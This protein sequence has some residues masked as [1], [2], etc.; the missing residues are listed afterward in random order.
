MTELLQTLVDFLSAHPELAGVVAFLIAMGEALLIVG[1]FVPSTVPLVAVGTLV[2]LGKLSFWP[3]LAWIGAG[4]V[5]GD[6]VSYWIGYI[7]RDRLKRS[8]PLARYPALV[9][10]GEDFFRKYGGMSIC[11][12]R[13]VPGV[14][15][16]IPGIAGMAGMTPLRFT[17][18]NVLSGIAW[19]LAHLIPGI[20]TGA[21]LGL[22]G[23][24]SGRLAVVIGGLLLIV[25]LAVAAGRWLVQIFLPL[26]AGRHAAVVA[27][28]RRRPGR[29]AQW[30]A[31]TFDPSHP[32]STG[33]MA[34]ALLLLIA[35]PAF[36][37]VA[38]ETETDAPLALADQSLLN[39]FAGL[40]TAWVDQAMVFVTMLGD[41]VVMVAC[42][43]VVTVY[44]LWRR[45]WG[46]AVGLLIAVAGT[47]LFV[48]LFK[49]VFQHSRPV[50][51]LYAGA[52]RFSFP[53]GHAAI[54][55]V[56]IGVVTVLAAHDR[57]RWIQALA[58]SFSAAYVTL[59]AFSRV[60]LGA[61]WMS[62]VLAGLL[63]GAAMAAV[64]AFVF[65]AEYTEKIGRRWLAA[66][67]VVTLAGVGGG[68]VFVN[69]HTSLAHYAP[70]P[71][72]VVLAEAEWRT[73][74][75]R[76][77]PARRIELA[78]GSEEPL[79][80]QWVG[81]PARLARELVAD[82]WQMPPSWSIASAS[83]FVYGRTPAAY[84]PALARLHKGRAP[85]LTMIRTD[86][87]RPEAARQVLRLWPTMFRVEAGGRLA[88]LYVGAVLTERVVRP[89]GQLSL[90]RREGE[91]VPGAEELLA[92][93]PGAIL[94]RRGRA[95]GAT[96]LAGGTTGPAS[97]A[98]TPPPH[99]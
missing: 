72:A 39:L 8:W 17:V 59:M 23:E 5:L 12:G 15:A 24:V 25:F 80:L 69:Y 21:L 94:V 95:H 2:G 74:D 82:G 3:M 22:L 85:V 9:A 76:R 57:P 68:H 99:D 55:T 90:I 32:R 34:S 16:V 78:G 53:S 43:L 14:K 28:C 54:N 64:F 26:F 56:L 98:K 30:T 36:L 4:A 67:F 91:S 11:F 61:H 71:A 1:L 93:L 19:A 70:R 75:W 29:L 52:D 81:P 45:A 62:D 87:S 66:L 63:F 31:H 50:E 86:P 92:G 33:M 37:Y 60:Y 42:T 46:P 51:L 27:W 96:V 47:A 40:R 20:T 97:M 84:L 41:G 18:I 88:R 35:V 10:R 77:L 79:V 13:F 48:T 73:R 7:W 65:G 38:G 49:L 58:V 83:G 89:F 6:Q 44:L